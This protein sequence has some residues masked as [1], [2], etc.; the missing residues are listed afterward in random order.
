MTIFDCSENPALP[1]FIENTE[2][3][4]IITKQIAQSTMQREQ[5]ILTLPSLR[6]VSNHFLNHL[7]K[8]VEPT[9]FHQAELQVEGRQQT[10]GY[11]STMLLNHQRN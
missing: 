11:C 8:S 1:Y 4:P 7:C 10:N 9:S 2:Q 5:H 6:A 3:S